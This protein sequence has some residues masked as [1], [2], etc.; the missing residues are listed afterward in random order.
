M[1]GVRI[2]LNQNDLKTIQSRLNT[3]SHLTDN[4]RPGLNEIGDY[5][6]SETTQR[7]RDSKS[8]QGENW[9]N[10]K[11][12]GKPLVDHGHLRDSIHYQATNDSVEIG[13]NLVYAA[14]HQLGGQAGRGR[15]VTIAARPF[16]GVNLADEREIGDIL[17]KHISRQL[18]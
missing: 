7:F 18:Q 2:E 16:L 4:L 12:G 3:L 6:V 14:I 17:V 1:A 15:K 11:R 8:P 13:S 10:V 5:L 9:K